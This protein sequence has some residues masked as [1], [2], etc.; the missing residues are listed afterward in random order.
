MVPSFVVEQIAHGGEEAARLGLLDF[1]WGRRRRASQVDRLGQLDGDVFQEPRRVRG[2]GLPR[3]VRSRARVRVSRS[4]ARV[5][6]T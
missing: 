5:M 2:T 3:L 4:R 6:P 1:L